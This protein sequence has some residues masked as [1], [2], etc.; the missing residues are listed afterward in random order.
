MLFG[1]FFDVTNP[2]KVSETPQGAPATRQSLRAALDSEG[3][4]GNALH[5]HDN[6]TDSGSLASMVVAASAVGTSVHGKSPC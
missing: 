3:I 1:P 6:W 5:N 2:K 4:L